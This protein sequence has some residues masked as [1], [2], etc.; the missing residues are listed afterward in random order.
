MVRENFPLEFLNSSSIW[1]FG[2]AFFFALRAPLVYYTFY[3]DS[4]HWR[5]IP[6]AQFNSNG[7][8]VVDKIAAWGSDEDDERSII[9]T[10]K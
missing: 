8:S 1:F 4:I 7:T 2:N 5:S 3:K 9:N 10:S 6:G